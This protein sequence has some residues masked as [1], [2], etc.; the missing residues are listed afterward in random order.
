MTT[1][2]LKKIIVFALA[3]I[4]NAQS[5][6]CVAANYSELKRKDC[7]KILNEF[8]LK[9]FS[10]CFDEMEY[11][12]NTVWITDVSNVDETQTLIEGTFSYRDYNTSKRYR[13]VKFKSVIET[14]GSE[15]QRINFR[16]ELPADITHTK[17]YWKECS[18]TFGKT[19]QKKALLK[20]YTNLLN[21]FCKNNYSKCFSG[22]TYERNSIVI[23]NIENDERGFIVV[24]GT[25]T[26]VGRTGS[27]YRD[28]KFEAKI[29]ETENNIRIE[30]NKESAPDLTHSNS[31][32]EKCTK[33]Y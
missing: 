32:W 30:F 17:S 1:N 10:E 23:K 29:E 26:Y 20:Y 19:E 33:S 21:Q 14:S 15:I 28:Y 7:K 9:Y 8:C 11:V 3:M 18:K 13:A 5:A 2:R 6:V 25:H 4:V 16:M 31:Y 12:Q 27:V 24:Y 22:R